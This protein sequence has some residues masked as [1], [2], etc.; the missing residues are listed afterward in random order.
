MPSRRLFVAAIGVG[1]AGCLSES[2]ENPANSGDSRE[3]ATETPS[4]T[5]TSERVD[6]PATVEF[7]ER[8]K[9]LGHG[10]EARARYAV[11]VDS[12]PFY[13]D[14]T[15]EIRRVEYP[16]P[17]SSVRFSIRATEGT[18]KLPQ[19]SAWQ[20]V[21]SAGDVVADADFPA[22]EEETGVETGQFRPE[23]VD[24]PHFSVL[25]DVSGE[26]ILGGSERRPAFFFPASVFDA[27]HIVFSPP[28]GGFER[29]E[30]RVEL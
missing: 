30:W 22:F 1:L 11:V 4:T 25:T 24:A 27:S 9:S 2:V 13:D 21:D 5:P 14:E 29:A 7:T 28:G 26:E 16:E 12:M 6:F 20:L 15:G 3:N 17:L 10:V 23:H 18:V 19:P 8:P